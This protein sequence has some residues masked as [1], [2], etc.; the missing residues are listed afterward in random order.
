MT[1]TSWFILNNESDI[2]FLKQG[3]STYC[4]GDFLK[5]RNTTLGADNGIA[6]AMILAILEN[7]DLAMPSIEA[8]FT[9]DEEIGMVGAKELDTSLLKSNK[10]INIDYF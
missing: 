2:D 8:V 10:M 9:T 1:Q 6:V 3:I 7:D 4:E 5:A